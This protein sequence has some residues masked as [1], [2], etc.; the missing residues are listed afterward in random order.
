M[1]LPTVVEWIRHL[2]EN[3]KEVVS[4]TLFS[5]GSGYISYED[6]DLDEEVYI[7]SWKNQQELEKLIKTSFIWRHNGSTKKSS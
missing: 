2:Q 5:D 6:W 7:C 4:I 1:K 3:R